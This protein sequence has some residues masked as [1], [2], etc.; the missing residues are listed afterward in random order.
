MMSIKIQIIVAAIVVIGLIYI[1][2]LIRSNRLE[3]KHAFSWITVGIM[4]LILDCFPILMEKLSKIFG[5]ALPI[6]MMFFVGFIFTLVIILTMSVA[7]SIT[8]ASVK[9]LVQKTALLE[10]RIEELEK[11]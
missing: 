1:F 8:S 10:K 5:I 6:N 3:L 2:S 4:V 11:K 7:L 9:R